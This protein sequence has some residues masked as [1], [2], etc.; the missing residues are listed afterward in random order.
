MR[1]TRHHDYDCDDD[2]VEVADFYQAYNDPSSYIAVDNDDPWSNEA[3][4]R[5]GWSKQFTTGSMKYGVILLDYPK[6]VLPSRTW[7]PNTC[8]SSCVELKKHHRIEVTM[9]ATE[10]K[11]P[12]PSSHDPCLGGCTEF[13]SE[14]SGARFIRTTCKTSG[15]VRNEERRHSQQDPKSCAHR[16]T[17]HRGS[18]AHIRKTYWIDCGTYI[19]SV[20]CEIFDE[21]L[22]TRP[23]SSAFAAREEALTNH[24]F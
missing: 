23:V 11:Q 5:H 19:Y 22:W 4:Y 15:T 21:V 12:E 16:H 2:A 6:Q 17:D 3:D 1:T 20:P 13:S 9:S 7:C 18:N 8:P 10:R 14:G 24:V